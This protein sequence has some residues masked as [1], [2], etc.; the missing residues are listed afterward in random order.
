MHTLLL[1][2]HF[3]IFF[4][5]LTGICKDFDEIFHKDFH[6]DFFSI[7]LGPRNRK[8]QDPNHCHAVPYPVA[9]PLP[10]PL[11]PTR[12]DRRDLPKSVTQPEAIAIR[13][14]LPDSPSPL[15]RSCKTQSTLQSNT[16]SS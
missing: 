7:E 11:P 13:R 6:V 2:S 8:T 1:S 4:D 15:E 5:I 16:F 3:L 10:P 9:L 12:K 14:S